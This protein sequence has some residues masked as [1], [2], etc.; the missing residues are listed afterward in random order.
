M[1]TKAKD[2]ESKSPYQSW[3]GMR[4]PFSML[5]THISTK[6]LL[7]IAGMCDFSLAANAV[8]WITKGARVFMRVNATPQGG[9]LA[10]TAVP[11]VVRWPW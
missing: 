9:R 8:V 7:A 1:N 11:H 2:S 6:L 4:S 5:R 3:S 10:I